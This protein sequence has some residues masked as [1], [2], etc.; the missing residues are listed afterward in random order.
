MKKGRDGM[1]ESAKKTA[2]PV[3]KSTGPVAA[4]ADKARDAMTDR[5]TD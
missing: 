5:G 4:A 2:I 3:L 1:C